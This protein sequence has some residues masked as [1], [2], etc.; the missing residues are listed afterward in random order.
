MQT[1]YLTPKEVAAQLEVSPATIVRWFHDGAIPG[2]RI[3]RTIKIPR[4][5]IDAITNQAHRRE[6]K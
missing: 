1:K 3:H 4:T 6:M 2:I 5:A